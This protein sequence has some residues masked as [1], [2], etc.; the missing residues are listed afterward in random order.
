[1]CVH[2]IEMSSVIYSWCSLG[3]IIAENFQSVKFSWFSQLAMDP[4]FVRA[5]HGL[6]VHVLNFLYF[7][8]FFIFLIR[9]RGLYKP[10]SYIASATPETFSTLN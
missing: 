2:D 10:A 7:I 4:Y 9:A 3:I 1:M 5:F 6:R 8:F